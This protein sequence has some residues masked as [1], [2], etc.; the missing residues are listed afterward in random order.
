MS[1]DSEVERVALAF[2][3][4]VDWGG[5]PAVWVELAKDMLAM[6]DA[7]VAFNRIDEFLFHRYGNIWGLGWDTQEDWKGMAEFCFKKA[8]RRAE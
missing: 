1:D 6:R 4:A 3:N 2:R 5:P 7:G 8:A